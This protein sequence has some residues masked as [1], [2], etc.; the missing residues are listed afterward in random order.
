MKNHMRIAAAFLPVVLLATGCRNPFDPSCDVEF[1]ALIAG[2]M[3]SVFIYSYQIPGSGTINFDPWKVTA[4]FLVRNKVAALITYTDLDGNEVTA[5]K[6]TGG[7]SF[8]TTFR[9]APMT[10][11]SPASQGEG[12]ETTISL[13]VVDKKVLDELLSP[14]YPTNKF[15]FANIV[16]RGEDEN[17]YDVRLEGRIAIYYYQ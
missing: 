13:Y 17:G 14:S 16:F 7:R 10:S 2:N 12:T 8:R 11:N 1:T 6:A 3:N 5:Y 9:L 15:M 4:Q